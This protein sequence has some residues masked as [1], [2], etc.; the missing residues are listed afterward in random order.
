V[1]ATYRGDHAVALETLLPQL[2]SPWEIDE[3]GLFVKL[4]PCC[5]CSHRPI[6]GLLELM[7]RHGIRPEEVLEV[8]I[9]F[10]PGSDAG[11]LKERP[12]TGLGGKF[13]IEYTAAAVLVDGSAGL[14]S[15]TDTAFNRPQ[16]QALM[17]KVR[18]YPI[19]DGKRW[20]STVGY[21][22]VA[23]DTLR[24]RFSMRVDATPGSPKTPMPASQ[25]DTK[26]L[27]C[28]AASM[29]G[30]RAQE[31]LG[32]LR[33]LPEL[34]DCRPLLECLANNKEETR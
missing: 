10:P 2:G 30:D 33:S 29:S 28:A 22:D 11:L 12:T 4:W 13:S 5:Y 8:A 21:N 6:A 26:F 20:S 1:L 17:D 16:V 23:I 3:P 32:L 27:D 31:A 24:G 14:A 7:E 25:L 18:S 9:G 19:E 34:P 15:F